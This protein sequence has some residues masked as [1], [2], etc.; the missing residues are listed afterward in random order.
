MT[1]RQK[2]EV[3]L[4]EDEDHDQVALTVDEAIDLV[5]QVESLTSTPQES[6]LMLLISSMWSLNQ[7]LLGPDLDSTSATIKDFH[8]KCDARYA[9]AVCKLMKLHPDNTEIHKNALLSISMLC[10]VDSKEANISALWEHDIASIL[11]SC[12][13]KQSLSDEAAVQQWALTALANVV[14][15]SEDR[16]DFMMKPPCDARS[17]ILSSLAKHAVDAGVQHA[18]LLA[19]GT[20]CSGNDGRKLL[21]V[22]HDTIEA[23]TRA[24]YYHRY[25]HLFCN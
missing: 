22:Q 7:F 4:D 10:R 13:R 25:M 6:Q 15:G 8:R 23:I 3:E 1:K 16:K 2:L 11:G 21:F 12:F 5:T 19:L 24:L 14:T 17:A 18:G 20:F 9:V